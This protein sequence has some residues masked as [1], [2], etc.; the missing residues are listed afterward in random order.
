MGNNIFAQPW[1]GNRESRQARLRMLWSWSA[2]EGV[3]AIAAASVAIIAISEVADCLRQKH[4]VSLFGLAPFTLLQQK[5][6]VL[7]LLFIFCRP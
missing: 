7:A 5:L 1:S 2:E 6:L 3:F 4:V